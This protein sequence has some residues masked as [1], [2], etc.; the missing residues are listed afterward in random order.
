MSFNSA[1]ITQLKLHMR[2]KISLTVSACGTWEITLTYWQ[3]LKWHNSYFKRKRTTLSLY[4]ILLTGQTT[5]AVPT[6]KISLI[7]KYSNNSEFQKETLFPTL[8]HYKTRFELTYQDAGNTIHFSFF[9]MQ[10][11]PPSQKTTIPK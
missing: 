9:L 11:F 2:M 8:L 1:Y 3:G 7:Y 6:P 10:L 4:P 5:H